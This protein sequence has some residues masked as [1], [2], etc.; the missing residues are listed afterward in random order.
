MN[1][2]A[3]LN[4]AAWVASAVFAVIILLDFLKVE[5]SRLGKREDRH[6]G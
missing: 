3:M 1:G 4:G 5:K 6:D 2:W